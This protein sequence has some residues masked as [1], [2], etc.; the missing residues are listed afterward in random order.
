MLSAVVTARQV[1]LE[2]QR[3]NEVASNSIVCEVSS[4]S[5]TCGSIDVSYQLSLLLPPDVAQNEQQFFDAV[6]SSLVAAADNGTLLTNLT[7]DS[8]SFT[9][10]VLGACVLMHVQRRF[11]FFFLFFFL[12]PSHNFIGR[13]QLCVKLWLLMMFQ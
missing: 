7:V 9:L 10:G 5:F 13:L 2:C 1:E 11:S 4:V 3:T 8:S 6:F 12:F